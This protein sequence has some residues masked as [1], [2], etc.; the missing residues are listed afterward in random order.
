MKWTK[1]FS[2]GIHEIDQQHQILSD[3][4]TSLENA[5]VGQ[6]RWSAVHIALI[7][8]TDFAWIHFAVEEAL[9][10]IHDYP[11]LEEHIHEHRQFSEDLK[12]LNEKALRIDVS[13]ETIAFI[14]AWLDKH[15]VESDKRYALHFLKRLALDT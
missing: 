7:N 5:V 14:R 3:C 4:I 10:R 11:W 15:V 2:V 8:L 1:E 13:Q 12:R 9:M 6:E